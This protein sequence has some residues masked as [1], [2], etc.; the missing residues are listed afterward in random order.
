MQSGAFVGE[1]RIY[2]V[3]DRGVHGSGISHWNVIYMG[4]PR[5]WDSHMAYKGIGI[6]Q[7]KRFINVYRTKLNRV[8]PAEQFTSTSELTIPP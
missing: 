7:R 1:I 3:Q 2:G 4:I 5:K 6:K 8:V